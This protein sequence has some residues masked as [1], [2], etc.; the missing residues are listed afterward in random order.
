[1]PYLPLDPQDISR[2]YEVIIHINWQSGKGEVLFLQA[3]LQLDL[4]S[5]LQLAF[6]NTVKHRA[7]EL[8]RTSYW[9]ARSPSSPRQLIAS[10][11]T[12]ALASLT[13]ATPPPKITGSYALLSGETQ[14]RR[15]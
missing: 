4:P 5:G 6:S 8:G 1:M 2:D 7:G 12:T 11:R 3:K 14:K 15:A 9:P 13:R 10:A